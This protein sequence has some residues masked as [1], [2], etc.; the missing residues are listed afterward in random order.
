MKK[1][2]KNS[3]AS[4]GLTHQCPVTT[5]QGSILHSILDVLTWKRSVQKRISTKKQI[6][7]CG[8]LC[9]YVELIII[10]QYNQVFKYNF[11]LSDYQKELQHGA[12]SYWADRKAEN[13][14]TYEV[15][16]GCFC[17]VIYCTRTQRTVTT[18]PYFF[19]LAL[20]DETD[21]RS[22]L[23][24]PNRNTDLRFARSTF[25]LRKTMRWRS[26]ASCIQHQHPFFAIPPKIL[27]IMQKIWT[28]LTL[29]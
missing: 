6:K 17:P 11:S 18:L 16:L 4:G 25:N 10:I 9:G 12:G 19:R 7:P 14:S 15:G 5:K 20:L 23:K 29:Q 2:E 8:S 21:L 26:W 28:C 27:Y 13:C 24:L 3:S 22:C 1:F